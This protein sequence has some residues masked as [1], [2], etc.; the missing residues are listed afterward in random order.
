MTK[1]KNEKVEG[2]EFTRLEKIS[3]SILIEERPIQ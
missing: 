3:D 2:L 1:M